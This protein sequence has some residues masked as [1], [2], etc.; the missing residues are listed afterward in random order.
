MAKRAVIVEDMEAV[1]RALSSILNLEGFEEVK[2][3]TDPR[4]ALL[5]V[6]QADPDLLVLDVRMPHLSGP[7]VIRTLAKR[8]G[9]RPGLLMYSAAETEEVDAELAGSG[10]G[11]DA[12]L[13]KPAS[14]PELKASVKKVLA[15][16]APH[17]G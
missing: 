8:P 10:F 14:L 6:R 11:Y 17:L 2:V 7:Q 4:D 3:V 13:E 12:Y 16:I 1:A 15:A 5:A 9:E